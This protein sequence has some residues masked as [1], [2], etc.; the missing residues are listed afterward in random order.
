MG[1]WRPL[2]GLGANRH[3]WRQ[4]NIDLKEKYGIHTAGGQ[5]VAAN[6]VDEYQGDLRRS[7]MVDAQSLDAALEIARQCPNIRYGGSVV[8]L[9]EYERPSA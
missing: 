7:S 2:A 5:V 8:V 9:E 3:A 6:G 4:W 1:R